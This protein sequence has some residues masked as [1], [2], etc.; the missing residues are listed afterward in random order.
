LTGKVFC[1]RIIFVMINK[2]RLIKLTQDLIRIDSQNP[3]NNEYEIARWVKAY[4]GRIGIPARLY[5]FLPKRTNVVAG[6]AGENRTKS[7]LITP[8]LDTVPAGSAWKSDPFTAKVKGAKLYGLGATDCKGNLACALEVINS[9]VEEKI[10]PGCELVFAATANEESG[11][12]FGLITLLD[13]GVLKPDAAVVL[14]A[15]DFEVVVTQK[16]LIHLKIIIS[17]KKAH[18]AYPWLGLNAIDIGL[19]ILAE[20]KCLKLCYTVN[21]YLKPPT[22]NIGTIK[23]G[24][25]VNVVAD[26]C[27][28]ELDFRYLPGMSSNV[29]LK[30]IREVVSKHAKKFVLEID[31]VQKPYDI[32]P[33]HPLVSGLQNAGKKF[34]L[35]CPVRGSEG[36][37]V[38]TFFQD[39]SIPAIATGFGSEGMAHMA[40]EYV[41]VDNLYKGS[42]VLEEFLK[43]YKFL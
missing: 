9:L 39:K 6:V 35:T 29:L 10:K 15:D 36:A 34:G 1:A 37:T 16:G 2:K 4:L 7:L 8:H 18:G 32:C 27:E 21:K 24:D 3:N 26:R 38:I 43:N 40:D 13:K 33:E 20:L 5:E 25:K 19:K 12:E 14:D 28:F 31:G 23:G 11:S 30:E 17:G 22:M 42:L 41:A